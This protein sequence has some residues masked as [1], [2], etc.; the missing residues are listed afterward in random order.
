MKGKFITT[1]SRPPAKKQLTKPCSDCPWRVDAVPGWLGGSTP[2][3]WALCV[4]SDARIQ[5][6]VHDNVQCAGA[7]IHRANV[8]K[9]PRDALA[10]RLPPDKEAVF[11]TTK[12]F[13]E[14]HK[15]DLSEFFAKQ[16]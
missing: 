12:Q 6:H 7:A 3:E 9:S 8:V 1:G 16:T 15:Q 13:V 14:Y 11:A 4:H 2:E 10:L 5:C